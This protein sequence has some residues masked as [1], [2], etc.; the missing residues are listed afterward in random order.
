MTRAKPFDATINDLAALG[1]AD[2]VTRFG[3]LT[4]LPVQLLNVDLSTMA[5]AADVVLGIGE[6]L[7]E[8][9]YLDAQASPLAMKHHDLLWY[10]ALLH[11]AYQVPVHST[12]LACP[13]PAMKRALR[14]TPLSPR[15]WLFCALLAALCWVKRERDFFLVC[16]LFLGR[17]Q[18]QLRE[19]M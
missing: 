13:I 17:V 8:V 10:N 3:G 4:T 18:E 12:V 16:L 2:F 9:F 6:P 7:A 1:P 14:A 11:R 19:L 5:T 15:C